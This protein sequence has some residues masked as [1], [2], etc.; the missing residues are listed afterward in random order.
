MSAR[1][2][3]E[4]RWRELALPGDPDAWLARCGLPLAEALAERA[5]RAGRGLLAGV[6]GAQGTGK[7]T[8]CQL[9]VPLLE[10]GFGLRALVLALDDFYLPRAER[11]RLA[12]ELH[13]LLAT[14]GVPG[15]HELPLL[16]ATLRAARS[17]EALTLPRFDKARDDRAPEPRQVHGRFDLVLLEGWCVGA[18]PESEAELAVPCNALEA[19]Q[20]AD[21]RY[22]R[23]VNAQLAGPY[24]AL[25][26]TLDELVYFAAPDFSSVYGFRREQEAPLRS[27]GGG[28]DDAELA[29]FIAHFER[30]TR[31]MLRELP[32][33]ADVLVQL[34]AARQVTSVRAAQLER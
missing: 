8:A 23:H 14:R 29:R 33:R 21:G 27:A 2:W 7:S 11:L 19:E 9:L 31:H 24:A 25:F 17:G 16:A 12:R 28:M 32:G 3:V 15:T 1:A 26:A 18:R 5:R 10:R 30:I 6:A 34:D 13:P 22:R 4:P 20:D